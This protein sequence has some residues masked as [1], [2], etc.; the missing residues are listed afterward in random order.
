MANIIIGGS[1][2]VREEI[3]RALKVLKKDKYTAT[4]QEDG[5]S[6]EL[7]IRFEFGAN[8]QTLKFSKDEQRN[9]GAIE[10]KIVDGL[11]I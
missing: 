10:K 7:S 9:K 8:D 6:G 4:V 1:P 3:E 5:S 11:D 2:E